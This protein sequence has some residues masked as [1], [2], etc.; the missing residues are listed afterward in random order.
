MAYNV[1]IIG[2]GS[3]GFRHAEIFNSLK[4]KVHIISK[5]NNSK[6]LNLS[7]L[8]KII[9][10]K[11][12]LIL[13]SN[14]TNLHY[15]TLKKVNKYLLKNSRTICLVEKPLFHKNYKFEFYKK[16]IF[17]AYNLRFH[18]LIIKLK[19]LIDL[20]KIYHVS[21]RCYS[22]LPN[23]KKINYKKTYSAQKNKGG[24]VHN[25]LSHEI[26]LIYF[27][28]GDIRSSKTILKKISDLQISSK[29]ILMMIGETKKNI[30]FSLNLTYFSKIP[31]RTIIVD[32]KNFNAHLDFINNTLIIKNKTKRYKIS[33]K[34]DLMKS[35]FLNMNK[36][37]ISKNMNNL[38]KFTTGL[39]IVRLLD[40]I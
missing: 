3:A 39:K 1:L 5:R 23:W 27:L 11:F 7:N 12:N 25:D 21:L 35:S 6:Y 28:F 4:S 29:D 17:V 31:E 40:E 32:G 20:N 34:I 16:N 24:G 19:K 13:I 9:D 37:I 8:S 30:H 26:D 15:Q 22:Y 2:F 18:P 36:S 38:C 33:S 14:E 10:Y